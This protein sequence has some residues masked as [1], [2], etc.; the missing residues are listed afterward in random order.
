MRFSFLSALSHLLRLANTP[1]PR[2]SDPHSNTPFSN[3]VTEVISNYTHTHTH[4]VRRCISNQH[5]LA[6]SK[7]YSSFNIYRGGI[8]RG[9]QGGTI[10]EEKKKVTPAVERGTILNASYANGDKHGAT[11]ANK[12]APSFSSPSKAADYS[13]IIYGN[14]LLRSRNCV[15]FGASFGRVGGCLRKGEQKDRGFIQVCGAR[16]RLGIIIHDNCFQNF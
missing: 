16:N 9:R 6:I 13:R 14:T 8:N 10:R 7:Q 11:R 2:A 15:T 12:T 5:L 4:T 1:P 3:C